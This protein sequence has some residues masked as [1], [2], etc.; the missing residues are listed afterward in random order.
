MCIAVCLM[1]PDSNRKRDGVRAREEGA[2]ESMEMTRNATGK[3]AHQAGIGEWGLY[4]PILP[5]LGKM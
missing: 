3:A 5:F 1:C 4:Y 2:D